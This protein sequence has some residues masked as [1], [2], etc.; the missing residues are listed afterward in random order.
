MASIQKITLSDGTVSHEIRWKTPDRQTRKKRFARKPDAMRFKTSVEHTVLAGSYVDP[1]DGRV[2]ILDYG[3]SWIDTQV[4]R[5][6]TQVRVEGVLKNYV[7][8]TLGDRPLSSVRT[9]E[10]QAFVKDL[11]LTLAP[12]TVCATY[13]VLVG[14]V[15][16]C[17]A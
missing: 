7:I 13:G 9:T 11:T 16:G 1:K 8:P 10:V 14:S 4:W 2:T 6:S 5:P 17:R 12:S 3:D 15:P